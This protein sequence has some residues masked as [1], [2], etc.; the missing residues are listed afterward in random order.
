MPNI[1]HIYMYRCKNSTIRYEIFKYI[2]IFS[3]GRF[4]GS[5]FNGS[6]V[7]AYSLRTRFIQC[8]NQVKRS[9]QRAAS[10]Q[11][12]ASPTIERRTLNLETLMGV[13]ANQHQRVS[14]N[15]DA[16]QQHGRYGHQ[17]RQQATHGHGDAD[18]IVCEGEDQILADL[19][20]HC[21]G[22]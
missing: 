8:R 20:I 1:Q 2:G 13:P 10:R 5:G 12:R 7:L 22:K 18:D 3:A 15:A 9:Q 11:N 21:C 19:F 16:A 4:R 6:K 17:R 14:N